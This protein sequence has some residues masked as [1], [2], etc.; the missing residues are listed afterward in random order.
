M[1]C[2]CVCIGCNQIERSSSSCGGNACLIPPDGPSRSSPS[3]WAFRLFDGVGDM[4]STTLTD[5]LIVCPSGCGLVGFFS[6]DGMDH[7]LSGLTGSEF[8]VE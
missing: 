2:V 4:I 3:I 5:D 1:I 7:S 8:W 6:L